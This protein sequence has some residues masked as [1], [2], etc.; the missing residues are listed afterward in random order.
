[1][2]PP[3]PVYSKEEVETMFSGVLVDSPAKPRKDCDLYSITQ[4]Q[5]TFNGTE[6]ICLPFK[7][8]FQRCLIGAI[9]EKSKSTRDR[10]V[11]IESWPTDKADGRYINIEVTTA[12][13]NDYLSSQGQAAVKG[14]ILKRFMAADEVLRL[15]FEKEYGDGSG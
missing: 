7:R 14:D 9:S 1:M 3:V 13:D 12:K 15:K 5:C 4:N 6:V 10:K 8:L 11:E 2:A